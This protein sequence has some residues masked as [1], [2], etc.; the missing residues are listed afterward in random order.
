LAV[1][2][3]KRLHI[4]DLT[5]G[6]RSDRLKSQHCEELEPMMFS[7]DGRYLVAGSNSVVVVWDWGS[8]ERHVLNE[9]FERDIWIGCLAV[10][11]DSLTGVVGGSHA[12]VRSEEDFRRTRQ[13]RIVE[14]ASGRVRFTA[15]TIATPTALA[16]SP[17]GASLAIGHED[18]AIR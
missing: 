6:R 1:G 2:G 8:G 18:G 9:V 17:D 4:W 15:P 16:F 10:A 13:V 14:L 3:Q 7:P 12:G 11:P 5:T